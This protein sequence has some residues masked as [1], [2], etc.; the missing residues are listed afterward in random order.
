[1]I[2]SRWRERYTVDGLRELLAASGFRGEVIGCTPL[3]AA[4]R[5]LVEEAGDERCREIQAWLDERAEG[6]ERFVVVDDMAI[7]G[8][9]SCQVRTDPEKGL[10]DEHVG[11][12]MAL[13]G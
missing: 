12:V 6:I 11:A 10:C 3:R 1:V 13:L 9:A 2:S 7:G 8:M 4:D 5:G